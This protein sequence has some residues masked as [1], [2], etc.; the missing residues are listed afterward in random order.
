MFF[1]EQVR[2]VALSY[3]L[4]LAS[5][6]ALLQSAGA[7][8]PDYMHIPLSQLPPGSASALWDMSHV[9]AWA[10]F[11]FSKEVICDFIMD[12][13]FPADTLFIVLEEDYRFWPV[14]EDPQGCDDYQERLQ[15]IL[16]E[17]DAIRRSG[18]YR[19]DEDD[20]SVEAGGEGEHAKGRGR[21]I[22]LA[23]KYHHTPVP[24]STNPSDPN[25]G[26]QQEVADLIRMA[27]FCSRQKQSEIIW[28]GWDGSQKKTRSWPTKGSH[29]LMVTQHGA[30]TTNVGMRD[31]RIE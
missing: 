30:N 27:T 31:D 3:L 8:R 19:P 17:E 25:H 14:G 23:G 13:R 29:G 10:I 11:F 16:Q 1:C 6:L 24:A 18:A 7:Y 12:A 5:A 4:N 2:S 15:K 28:F 20:F 9:C 21:G 22:R 26:L